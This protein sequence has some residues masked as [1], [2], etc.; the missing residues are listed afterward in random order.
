MPTCDSRQ[1]NI[2]FKLSRFRNESLVREKRLGKSFR[3]SLNRG[4][5]G[6]GGEGV[7]Q[8]S[9]VWMLL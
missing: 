3:R 2:K 6:G 7:N 9:R 8:G 5:M 1:H 4:V